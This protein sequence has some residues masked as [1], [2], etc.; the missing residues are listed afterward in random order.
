MK[1]CLLII[2]CIVVSVLTSLA[3]EEHSDSLSIQYT[4][5]ACKALRD[6]AAAYDETALKQA[7]NELRAC[8]IAFFNGLICMED[9]IEPLNGHLI[10]DAV[11]AD[12]LAQDFEVYRKS[13]K[14]AQSAKTRAM[15]GAGTSRC[16]SILVKAG[17][18]AKYSF[19][20]AGW[21]ELAVVAEAGGLITMMVHV[22][23]SAGLNENHNDMTDVHIG[24]SDRKQSFMLPNTPPSTVE[25]E[26]LNCG[27]KDV[28]VV[29]ISN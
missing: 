11:F 7:A 12:S 1:K 27:K 18:K 14:F 15:I 26:V 22:T 6:A 13:E 19:R 2:A 25:L 8:D 29:V 10:F 9:S 20:A 23:N 24:R 4:I 16:K 28:S 17:A 21:Q 5:D 3:Q